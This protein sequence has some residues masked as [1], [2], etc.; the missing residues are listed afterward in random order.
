[1]KHLD[2]KDLS[3][4]DIH[5]LLL[6]G[7]APRPIALVST[8]SSDGISN[9]SPFSFFNAFGANPPIVAFSPN[10]RARDGSVKDTYN[11]IIATKECVINAV[12]YAMVEQVSLASAE[13]PPEVNEFI[14]SGLTPIPSD[15]VQA[16]RVKESPFQMEC[17]LKQMVSF[18]EQGVSANIA[19]CEVIRFHVA[20]DII[21][22]GIIQPDL[23]DLAARMSGDYYCRASGD[24]VFIVQKP[25][26]KKC[27]GIDQLPDFIK[28]SHVYS[29]NNL[30]KF[31]NTEKLPD[32]E[33]VKNA[34][35]KIISEKKI[36][37]DASEELF[38]RY[39]RHQKY[40]E[41]FHTALAL[42]KTNNPKAVMFM[43]L[44]AKC[45]IENNA[46]DFAL[47]AAIYAA[48]LT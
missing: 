39:Q 1:M 48:T 6:G 7:V 11:N 45:A 8:V 33:E 24:A 28:H 27:I 9:L 19:I 31:A 26:Q 44:S 12:T 18:G 47:M 2:P 43:E 14:I 40:E 29:A 21:E 42:E 25:E 36:H 30:A 32:M 37:D 41:M 10:R 46:N 34:V 3:V 16:S 22:N 23:I 35:K 4:R 5:R 15:L 38:F 17:K 20:E 13:Y